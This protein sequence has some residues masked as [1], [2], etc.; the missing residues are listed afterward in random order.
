MGVAIERVPVVS[1]EPRLD[2]VEGKCQE[3]GSVSR[4]HRSIL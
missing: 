3:Q 4:R 1:L 2:V